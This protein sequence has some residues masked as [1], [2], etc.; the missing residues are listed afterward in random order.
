[1]S[2]SWPTVVVSRLML[3]RTRDFSVLYSKDLIMRNVRVADVMGMARL[4]RTS[5]IAPDMVA[6]VEKELHWQMQK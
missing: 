5:D 6:E 1:M 2:L 4:V 3:C